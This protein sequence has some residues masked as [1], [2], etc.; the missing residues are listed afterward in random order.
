MTSNKKYP[1]DSGDILREDVPL[2]GDAVPNVSGKLR[3]HSESLNPMERL[4]GGPVVVLA[5]G[6]EYHGTLTGASEYSVYIKTLT[7]PK[8]IPLNRVSRICHPD[9]RPHLDPDTAVSREFFDDSEEPEGG[10]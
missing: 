8:E 6:I 2:N 9:D 7:G 10:E 5:G 1:P 4:V 3:E